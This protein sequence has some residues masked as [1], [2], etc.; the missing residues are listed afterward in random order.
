VETAKENGLNPHAYLEHILHRLR[1]ID[2]NDQ[3]A[4]EALLPW[5]ESVRSAL[6]TIPDAAQL[7]S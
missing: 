6:A 5:S 4:I 1:W 2:A 7:S 3:S